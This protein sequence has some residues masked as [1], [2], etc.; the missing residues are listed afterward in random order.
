MMANILLRMPLR[1][2]PGS[3]SSWLI[4]WSRSGEI[5][6]DTR[7]DDGLHS[8]V[9]TNETTEE[10][11]LAKLQKLQGSTAH[12]SLKAME[13]FVSTYDK[14]KHFLDY[15]VGRP[16]K[17]NPD[18]DKEQEESETNARYIWSE[19]QIQMYEQGQ[20]LLRESQVDV[21][22]PIANISRIAT[23]AFTNTLS[24]RREKVLSKIKKGNPTAATAITRIAPSA[25]HM[26]GGDHKKLENV[27]KLNKDLNNSNKEGFT[28]KKKSGGG[29]GYQSHSGGHQ[30]QGASR[31]GGK[32][33]GGHGYGGNRG[34]GGNHGS[35]R[36]DADRKF[37]GGNFSRGGKSHK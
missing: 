9:E 10:K 15:W 7:L 12:L 19:Q 1:W 14:I 36:R 16:A 27:V 28:P 5:F 31:G 23:A 2:I 4:S 35:D 34:Y 32:G 20:H 3:P 25:S 26:F 11:E 21:A 29:S 17:A 37:R 8:I 22:E 6:A 13:G 30:G 18:F 33:R 24:K